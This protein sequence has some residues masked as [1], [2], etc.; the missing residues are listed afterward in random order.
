MHT[1]I[2]LPLSSPC[3]MVRMSDILFSLQFFAC[4][5]KKMNVCSHVSWLVANSERPLLMAFF[6]RTCLLTLPQIS[7]WKTWLLP[8]WHVSHLAV[9]LNSSSKVTM[10]SLI[11]V[12]LTWP[13]SLDGMPCVGM[14]CCC[15]IVI[16]KFM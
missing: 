10:G 7:L 1:L 3:V 13:V 9:G 4:K 5:L 8:C 16:Y 11:N 6:Q 2:N 14:V 12:V 15:V